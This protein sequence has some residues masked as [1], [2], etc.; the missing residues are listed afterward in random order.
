[1]CELLNVAE[2]VHVAGL[3]SVKEVYNNHAV[4][5]LA[6]SDKAAGVFEACGLTGGRIWWPQG[7]PVPPLFTACVLLLHILCLP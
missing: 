5:T 4:P 1:M 2:L 7:V 3:V 6:N